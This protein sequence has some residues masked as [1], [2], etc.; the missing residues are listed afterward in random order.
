MPIPRIAI[1]IRQPWAAL[2]VLGLKDIE[3]RTWKIPQR[4]IGWRVLI[5]A[6]KEIDANALSHARQPLNQAAAD[7]ATAKGIAPETYWRLARRWPQAFELGA[8][9]GSVVLL[10]CTEGSISPWANQTPG[11]RHW[12]LVSA[13][14]LDKVRPCAGAL[15]FFDPNKPPRFAER[16]G[17]LV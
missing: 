2:V 3:N 13:L 6:G 7:L 8:I 5:H 9:V 16:Q 11:I 14:P 12:R 4:R 10:G 1:S 15:G 17:A